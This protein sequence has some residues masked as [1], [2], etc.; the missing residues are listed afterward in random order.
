[1]GGNKPVAYPQLVEDWVDAYTPMGLTAENVAQQ[2]NISRERQDAFAVRSHDL[3]LKAIDEGRFKSQILP[4]ETEVFEEGT[5]GH[6]VA[7]KVVLDTDEGP[8]RGTSLK[9]LSKLRPVFDPT[10][11]VTAG[12]SSQMNDGAGAVVVMSREKA[13]ALGLKPLATYHRYQ[14]AGTPPEGMGVGPA[15]AIPKLLGKAGMKKEDIDLWEVNE[16]FASQALYCCEDVLGL[17]M[18]KVNV[19]GG[20]IALGHPLGCTGTFLT[21]KL[22]YE[23]ERQ[24]LR[25]GVVSMCIGGGMGAAGLFEREVS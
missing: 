2:F 24:N 18:D 20:A 25:Y 8:R 11:T 3:A 7:K 19:N 23:M 12:N 14:V 16:A 10:G 6:P 17:D 1:M 22:L 15:Y 5:E 9:I 21:C 13:N 4:I